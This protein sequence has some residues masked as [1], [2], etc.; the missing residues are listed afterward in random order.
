[1]THFITLPGL[2]HPGPTAS[3]SLDHL[4]RP[5]EDGPGDR[6]AEGLGGLT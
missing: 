2:A 1:M 6:E 4:F 5:E 3:R